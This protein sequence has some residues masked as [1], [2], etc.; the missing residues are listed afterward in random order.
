MI[1][2][3]TKPVQTVGTEHTPSSPVEIVTTKGREKG[4]PIIGYIGNSE[5]LDTWTK[6]GRFNYMNPHKETTP[7]DLVNVPETP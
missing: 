5:R 2:D 6:E 3:Y 4:R 1:F 7:Y